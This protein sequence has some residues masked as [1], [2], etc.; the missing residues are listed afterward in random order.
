MWSNIILSLTLITSAAIPVRGSDILD[1]VYLAD[2]TINIKL[3]AYS[4]KAT[5]LGINSDSFLHLNPD[6]VVTLSTESGATPFTFDHATQRLSVDDSNGVV[7]AR[8][9]L[10]ATGP[11]VISFKEASVLGN[12]LD[13]NTCRYD[14]WSLDNQSGRIGLVRADT[15]YLYI[16][17]EDESLWAGS[18]DAVKDDCKSVQLTMVV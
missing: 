15:K 10:L 11:G 8:R 12:C 2:S 7:F 14:I 16:C 18:K 4:I 5:G 1:T 17:G 6:G 3:P 9:D 13:F